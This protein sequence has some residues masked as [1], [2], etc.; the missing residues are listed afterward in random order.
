MINETELATVIANALENAINACEHVEEDGRYID[1]QVITV[2]HF[3][4]LRLKKIDLRLELRFEQNSYY[5]QKRFN[6]TQYEFCSN[7]CAIIM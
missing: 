3:M 2:P 7:K 1:V 4:N 6:F 5:T